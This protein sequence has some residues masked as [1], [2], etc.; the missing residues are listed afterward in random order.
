MHVFM[1]ANAIFKQ[2]SEKH[3]MLQGW[4][5][6]GMT[7]VP[8]CY[9]VNVIHAQISVI[10]HQTC[11]CDWDYLQQHANLANCDQLQMLAVTIGTPWEGL[12]M[13]CT[14]SFTSQAWVDQQPHHGVWISAAMSRCALP[15]QGVYECSMPFAGLQS[16]LSVQSS[17]QLSQHSTA[18]LA[19]TYQQGAGLG[20]QVTLPLPFA[21][22]LHSCLCLTFHVL[23]SS[24]EMFAVSAHA[25]CQLKTLV[26]VQ[27]GKHFTF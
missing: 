17:Y 5:Y 10:I 26:P 8:M 3:A 12:S 1:L 18:A 25:F 24:P 9:V 22:P 21:L 2:D 13:L 6:C 20:M 7:V 16:L 4:Q 27:I 14:A 19:L 15:V 11:F 23:P